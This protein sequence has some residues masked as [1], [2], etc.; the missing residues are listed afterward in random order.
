MIDKKLLAIL[1]LLA[2][3]VL[4]IKPLQQ[5]A[6]PKWVQLTTIRKSI[7]KEEFIAKQAEKIKSIYPVYEKIINSNRALFFPKNTPLATDRS[8]LQQMVKHLL[9][10]NGLEVVRINWGE[11]I[12]K[13]GYEK[14]P[15]SFT[16]RGYPGQIE[17][18]LKQLL[19]ANKLIRF[20]QISISKFRREKLVI[21]AI[22]V[23]FK[24]EAGNHVQD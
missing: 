1:I 23:G 17:T 20:E 9:E 16:A 5:E 2:G 18:F 22:I 3:Y 12:K 13:A 21:E 15:L 6:A 8:K 24:L 4:W 19:S 11:V 7:A 14:L 10:Q